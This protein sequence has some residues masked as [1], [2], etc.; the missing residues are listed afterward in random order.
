M[1]ADEKAIS[2]VLDKAFMVVEHMAF[3]EH[4]SSKRRHVPLR[5]IITRTMNGGHD[6]NAY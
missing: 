6:H 4:H 2:V 1:T 3:E 5:D